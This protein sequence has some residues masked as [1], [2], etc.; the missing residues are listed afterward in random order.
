MAAKSYQTVKRRKRYLESD[1]NNFGIS[2]NVWS[3]T[4]NSIIMASN[5]MPLSEIISINTSDESKRVTVKS[6]LR[7]N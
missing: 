4:S 3:Q 6:W 1:L 2:H 7:K 5:Y